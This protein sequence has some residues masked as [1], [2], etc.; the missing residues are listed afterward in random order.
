M[1]CT[2]ARRRVLVSGMSPLPKKVDLVIIGAGTAGSAAALFAARAGLRVLCVDRGPLEQA[3][4]HWVNGV[5]LWLHESVGLEVPSYPELRGHA[6][7]FHLVAGFGG[8]RVVVQGHQVQEV[9]MRHLGQRLR[10]DARTKGATLIGELEVR[11]VEGHIVDTSEGSVES[12]WVVDA[13][14]L[15]GLNLL[16]SPKVGKSDICV[17]AQEVRHCD[18]RAARDFFHSHDVEPG[19]TLCFSGIAGG[20]SIINVHVKDDRLS[21]LT[22]SI[23]GEGHASGRQLLEDFVA[24]QSW[25]GEREFGGAKAIPIRR[26]H[27]RLAQGPH[28]ALGDAASQVFP[29]H[30]SGIAPQIVAA[31][32]LAKN[33]QEG[34]GLQGYALQYQR[35]L[36]GRLAGYDMFRRFSQTLSTDDLSRLIHSGVMTQAST[37]AA[38]EQRMPAIPRPSEL[39]GYA[40]G[41]LSEPRMAA[42]LARVAGRMLSA[43]ELYKRYPQDP[44]RLDRW[45]RWARRLFDEPAPN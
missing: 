35:E 11:S 33:L 36:G 13:S 6:H 43:Q 19:D 38:L 37:R 15:S 12:Q 40:R 21:I 34:R 9:D 18:A 16:R 31:H 8:P 17:A 14:G 5:P 30:G 42:K 22:G 39:L 26:S 23:P 27:D 44:E 10:D 1:L 2:P 45:S 32:M 20:Y 29:A 28:A 41:L 4:A 7:K 25:I 3:G 24:E